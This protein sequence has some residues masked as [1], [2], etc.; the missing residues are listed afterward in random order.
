MLAIVRTGTEDFHRTRNAE[1]VLDILRG[2]AKQQVQFKTKELEGFKN[3]A[4]S[5]YYRQ[6]ASTAE[7]EMA[8]LKN[9]V[10]RLQQYTDA[11][12]AFL[13]YRAD[14]S[15]L[16]GLLTWTVGETAIPKIPKKTVHVHNGPTFEIP[17]EVSLSS[18]N[19]AF[20][21]R[22]KALLYTPS[23]FLETS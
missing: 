7:R 19:K 23:P 16:D 2:L 14:N 13:L 15:Q 4:T 11:L 1:K 5:Y 8:T 12:V 17:A 20:M 21:F 22:R 18:I 10:L 6:R 9:R 3:R